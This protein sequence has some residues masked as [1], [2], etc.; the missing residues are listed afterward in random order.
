[1]VAVLQYLYQDLSKCDLSYSFYN[2]I[3]PKSMKLNV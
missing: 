2:N 1:M 3:I